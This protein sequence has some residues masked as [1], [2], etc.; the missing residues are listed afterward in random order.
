MTAMDT[1][2]KKLIIMYHDIHRLRNVEHFT[3]QRIADHLL[4]NFRTVK[5]FLEMT[6]EEFDKFSENRWSKERLLDPYKDFIVNYLQKYPYTPAAVM[7]DKLKESYPDFPKVDPKTIYNFVMLLRRDFNIP[8]VSASERQYSAL[9]DLPPGQQAQVDFG[10]K[11]LRTSA[12]QWVKVYFFIMLLC[13]SRQ[14]FLLFRDKPFTSEE[15]VIAHEK[16][17]EFFRGIPSEIVYDQAS[18]FL[19]SENREDYRMT[20]AFERY[21]ASRPFKVIFC[22][23]SDPES[24][25][26]VENTI[27]Y[28]K[29]NFLFQRTF[30][31]IEILNQ[32]ASAWLLRTGNGMVHNTTR[33][34]PQE[35]WVVEQPYL[36]K[37]IPL[38]P[39]IKDNG[40]KVIKTNSIKYHGNIYSLPFGTYR[41][42]ETRAY[43]TENDN[44]LV[45]KDAGGNVLATHLIPEGVGNNVINTN[46]RRDTSL[47][48][49]ALREKTREFFRGSS[50]IELFIEK[51][52]ILYPR[53]VRD[54]LST[55]L[56]WAEKSGRERSEAALEFCVHNSLFSANDFK[57]ILENKKVDKVKKTIR[58][59]IKPLGDAKTQ[60][61]AHMEP[62]RSDIKEYELIFNQTL[63]SNEPVHTAY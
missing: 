30:I 10:E 2:Q 58:P 19:Y 16:A 44:Q 62:A 15:A 7:H 57:S 32:Q 43:V 45:I 38:Y 59:A 49:D 1:Q 9:A 25:G 22:R 29:G 33:K 51:I 18:V 3:I 55:V 21:Q 40:Y 12:G 27:K 63:Q 17:F 35:Q 60:L 5:K 24:K 54:Q 23:A 48:L 37:W 47:R 46:H 52:N 4:L 53:Y 56:L 34:I 8:K 6:Q 26:K 36:Q 41:N 11:K 50:S 42:E 31:S 61:I 14:K 13:F 39:T 20:E 28:T